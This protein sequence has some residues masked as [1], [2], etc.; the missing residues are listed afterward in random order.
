MP[1]FRAFV[2]KHVYPLIPGTHARLQPFT[3]IHFHKEYGGTGNKADL[4]EMLYMLSAVALFILFIAAV[5]FI[6][7][8]TAQSMQ[9]H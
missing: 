5:N 4:T 2:K 9:T 8:S 6:N 3:G 7:L 1:N